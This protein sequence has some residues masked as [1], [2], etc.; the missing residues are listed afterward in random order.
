MPDL[1]VRRFPVRRD[2]DAA[3]AQRLGGALAAD[4]SGAVM[5][6]G[7]HTPGPAYEM[8]AAHPPRPAPGLHLLYSDDR[9]VPSSSDASN[10]HLSQALVNALALPAAQVLRVP[11]ELPLE[12]AAQ[13]YEERLQAL[14]AQKIPVRLGLLGLG[15]DGHTASLFKGADLAAARGRLAIAVQRPDARTG[16]SVTPNFLARVEA[17]LFVVAGADKTAALK[18]LAARDSTLTAWRAVVKCRKV[19]IWADAEAWPA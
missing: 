4:C 19:E 1:P 3:L 16:I 12:A 7:G 9:Y 10:Y 11:T 15:A 17:I 2:L 13:A 18:R 14:L 8:L 6:A 5:L